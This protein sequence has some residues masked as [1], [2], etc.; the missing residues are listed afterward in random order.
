M[1]CW[2]TRTTC[3]D[4]ESTYGKWLSV[5][6]RRTS[7]VSAPANLHFHCARIHRATFASWGSG[8]RCLSHILASR[9][10]S[11]PV[12]VLEMRPMRCR[13][14][15][16]AHL[17][18]ETRSGC[19]HKFSGFHHVYRYRDPRPSHLPLCRDMLRYSRVERLKS[20]HVVHAPTKSGKSAPIIFFEYTTCNPLDPQVKRGSKF[21]RVI[22]VELSYP[23]LVFEWI[24]TDQRT[25]LMWMT[26]CVLPG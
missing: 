6:H 18:R 19:W 21:C 17:Y 24:Y 26:T 16:C 12:N 4:V 5:L 23:I 3:A 20:N 25:H 11:L 15:S 2:S 1:L 7:A 13:P 14:P 22:R 8:P 10:H 9:G